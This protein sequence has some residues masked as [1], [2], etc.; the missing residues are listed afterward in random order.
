MDRYMLTATIR[1]DG[2]SRFGPDY[3]WGNFP[4]A[5]FAWKII[6]EPFMKGSKVFSDL[7]LRVGWGITGQQDGIADYGYQPTINFGDSAA[8]YQFGNQFHT[9]ARP[10]GF[11]ASL[12]WEETESKN[13]GLDFGFIENRFNAQR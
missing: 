13:I 1:R 5:A 10:D 12:K 7:K 6:D 11:V 3:R 8:Q 4:S 9:I 2:S